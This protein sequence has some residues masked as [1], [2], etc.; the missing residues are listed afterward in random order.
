[1][2]NWIFFIL[3]C[4]TFSS[5]KKDEL[6]LDENTN[7]SVNAES[8]ANGKI[9][10]IGSVSMTEG[11]QQLLL[12]NSTLFARRDYTI[13]KYSL[14]NESSPSFQSSYVHPQASNFGNL[15]ASGSNLYAPNKDDGKIYVFGQSLNL[16]QTYTVGMSN[17][18]ANS[19]LIE[20]DGTWWI[21]GSNGSNGILVQC[22]VDGTTLTIL[23][24][25]QATYNESMME[26]LVVKGNYLY[27][28]IPKGDVLTFL[29]SDVVSGPVQVTTFTNEAGHEKWGRTII[30]RNNKLY[31]ANWGAGLA[32]IDISSPG[33]PS[34]SN[35][36]ANST[37]KNQFPNSEGT[38]VYDV[39]Y[40]ASKDVLC[41]ANG[42]SGVFLVSPNT[43]NVVVDYIDP[44][45]FQNSCIA[46]KGDYVY[47]GNISGGM[48]GDLKGIKV[49]KLQ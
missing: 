37:F 12:M 14:T 4:A 7:G 31:W 34:V 18:K 9:K 5:C 41:V 21:G 15:Y 16:V 13:F 23:N 17:F 39:V 22:E 43:P 8:S 29:K 27:A 36:L 10:L 45:Y 32:T 26:S 40:N 30:E 19:L 6:A 42:W 11:P 2:K 46:T 38:N 25:W 28:S 49:F 1:M 24:S 35:V 47:T 33:T 44:Q 20:S 48:S 3:V